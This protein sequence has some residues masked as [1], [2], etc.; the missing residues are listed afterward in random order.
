[1]L[2]QR[3]GTGTI[4]PSGFVPPAWDILAESWDALPQPPAPTVA[5]GPETITMGHDDDEADD[6]STDVAGHEFGWDNEHPKRDVHVGEFRIEWRPVTNGEFLEFYINGG[7]SLVQFPASWV[8]GDG[9]IQVSNAISLCK[10][11]GG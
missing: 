3:A 1:M 9:G 7:K 2:L 11:H 10:S 6:D 5:L 8:E 4:P